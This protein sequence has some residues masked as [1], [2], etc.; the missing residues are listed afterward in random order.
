MSHPAVGWLVAH[1][2]VSA[3]GVGVW[4]PLYGHRYRI[5]GRVREPRFPHGTRLG[6]A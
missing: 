5:P 3:G 1:A 4:S 6:Q 2:V